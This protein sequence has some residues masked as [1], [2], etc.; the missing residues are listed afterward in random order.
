[1]KTLL[2]GDR[3]LLNQRV[4]SLLER[5]GFEVQQA[6]PQ[7]EVVELLAQEP[8]DLMLLVGPETNDVSPDL[9]AA[10][11]D[12]RPSTH[13][14]LVARD[15][16]LSQLIP[17]LQP[18]IGKRIGLNDLPTLLREEV[19]HADLEREQFRLEWL[20][21]TEELL[22]VIGAASTVRDSAKKVVDRLHDVLACQ[23]CGL[24]LI[25]QPG[26]PPVAVASA[27]DEDLIKRLCR[28]PNAISEWLIE[29]QSP[30]LIRRGRATIPGIQREVVRLGLGPSIF[31]PIVT[32]EGL[33]GFLMAMR[34]PGGDP[35]S[36]SAF[37]LARLVT[38]AF[39]LRLEAHDDMASDDL[40]EMVKQ[41]RHQRQSLE[42]GITE[43]HDMVRRLA[44]EV[45]AIIEARKGQ[46]PE[47][48]ETVAKLTVALAEQLDMD[49]T[50]LEEAVYLRDIGLLVTPDMMV[51]GGQRVAASADAKGAERARMGFEVLSRVR[52]PSTCLE[53]VRHLHENYDGSG[54]PDGLKGEEIPLSA[55]VVRVVDDYI[56]MTVSGNG[57]PPT[58]SPVALGQML[59]ESGRLYD[60]GVVETFTKLIRAHGVTPEQETLSLIA[61][62]LRTPLTFLAGFSELL[63]AR[64][65][66]PNQ[67]KEMAAELHK[68]TEG[69][70]TLTE[71][72][73]E[74][75]RL[76]SG[77]VSLTWQWVDLKTL[78]EQQAAQHRAI[79][80][81]HTVRV[82]APS[83]EVRLRAD[84]TRI[85]QAI[86][87]LVSNAIKYSPSG[88][89]VA[90]KLEEGVEDV[91]VSVS[92]QGLGIPKDVLGRLFQ[93]FY[94]VQQVETRQIEGLGLGLALTKAIVEAHGGRIWVES[95]PGKGSMFSFSLLKQETGN[96]RLVPARTATQ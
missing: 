49:S 14:Y 18:A 6:S 53:V 75:S 36:D 45:A 66:L 85:T 68:Q 95:E 80:A 91:V 37:S 73:L 44:R 24:A 81:D 87:N 2:V 8:F 82:E 4:G 9:I 57:G 88:G 16:L 48:S 86:G 70:V 92:D 34:D 56:T 30:M 94:R 31:V 38:K 33:V 46:R 71:R 76:Q 55:R 63:A 83:Y 47:R 42:D 29:N 67:A 96:E 65:D 64:Q 60:P 17:R 5:N 50:H 58:P 52:L 43:W 78:V 62:E 1:M 40:R 41:E 35:F 93:P 79:S 72:L 15:G 21:Y 54:V 7:D 51:P 28:E 23:S 22:E 3:P 61:H 10:V 19:G 12:V 39:A 90:I 11:R 84:T 77:R 32:T 27:G 13:V 25:L 74:L 89:E 26:R 59:R 69:M 20:G